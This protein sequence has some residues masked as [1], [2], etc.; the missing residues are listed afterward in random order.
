[1][2]TSRR[3]FSAGFTLIELLVVIAIIA[4][5]AGLLLPALSKAKSKATGIYCMN[6]SRQL[7]MGWRLYAE[8]NNDIVPNSRD[9]MTGGLNFDPGN[10]SNFDPEID[11]KKSPIWPYVKTVAVFKC[12]AD[13]SSVRSKGKELPRVRSMAM[14]GWILLWPGETQGGRYKRYRKL[15]DFDNPGQIFVFLDEREDGINDGFFNVGVSGYPDKPADYVILDYPASYHS[16]KAAGFA[17]ADGHSE[18]HGWR[19]PRT[20][21]RLRKG[22][23]LPLGVASP[24]NPD[25]Y[26]MADH[27]TQIMQ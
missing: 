26:W 10:R 25:C 19:D 1:M 2:P 16:G 12:P 14:N 11:I 4:I 23:E 21:P 18:I 22:M 20:M 7:A 27:A 13:R 5:L 6:N 9:W 17:F 3:R 8:D 15:T 24:N